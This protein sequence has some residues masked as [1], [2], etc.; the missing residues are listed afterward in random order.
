MATE[1]AS[2]AIRSVPAIITLASFL[3]PLS[4]PPSTKIDTP[5]MTIKSGEKAVLISAIIFL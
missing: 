3:V 5:S 4:G 2:T 1:T